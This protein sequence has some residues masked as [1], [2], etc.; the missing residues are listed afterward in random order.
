ML[1]PQ[2]HGF[3]GLG[4]A[5]VVIEANAL[6]VSHGPNRAVD[7]F[8]IHTAP[9]PSGVD[10]E[11]RDN[12]ITSIDELLWLPAPVFPRGFPILA[13]P[14]KPRI[15]PVIARVRDVVV[16]EDDLIVNRLP[17]RFPPSL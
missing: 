9:A 7:A 4:L 2:P 13:P 6:A 8:D 5:P 11:D 17:K 3:E 15:S 16:V 10:P 12:T 14:R 1:L